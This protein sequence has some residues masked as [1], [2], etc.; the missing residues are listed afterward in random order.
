MIDLE[1]ISELQSEF[2][3]SFKQRLSEAS[4]D[5]RGGSA[6]HSCRGGHRVPLRA[7][8]YRRRIEKDVASTVSSNALILG[9]C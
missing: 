2:G 4:P 9:V 8:A 1:P 6:H 5:H 7:S 3:F